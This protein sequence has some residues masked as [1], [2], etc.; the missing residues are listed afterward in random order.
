MLCNM[1][2]QEDC[3]SNRKFLNITILTNSSD[4]HI[5]KNYENITPFHPIVDRTYSSETVL[6]RE[7]Q[8]KETG[9][10][11]AYEKCRSSKDKTSTEHILFCAKYAAST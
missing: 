5:P 4:L 10:R 6:L 3:P 11:A 2:K 8:E 7:S 1:D 9:S